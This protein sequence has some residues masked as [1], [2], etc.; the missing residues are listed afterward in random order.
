M[1]LGI[2]K[3]SPKQ[4][5]GPR[6]FADESWTTIPVTRHDLDLSQAQLPPRVHIAAW[7]R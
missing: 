5:A 1:I 7:K 6:S 4:A 3:E 2:P